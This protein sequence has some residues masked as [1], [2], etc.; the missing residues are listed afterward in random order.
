MIYESFSFLYLYL[1]YK[2]TSITPLSHNYCYNKIHHI[3]CLKS[4]FYVIRWV[5]YGRENIV[6]LDGDLLN[7]IDN[8]K[9]I[10]IIK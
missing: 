8:E 5:F 9:K 7:L 6:M 3:N 1:Y 10:N 2:K 4:L